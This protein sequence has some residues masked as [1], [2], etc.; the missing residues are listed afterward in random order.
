MDFKK[1]MRIKKTKMRKWMSR[2]SPE[3][4]NQ[5]NIILTIYNTPIVEQQQHPCLEGNASF[6]RDQGSQTDLAVVAGASTGNNRF[7]PKQPL[8]LYFSEDCVIM[9]WP[10]R[11]TLI[12]TSS[13]KAALQNQRFMQAT[14]TTVLK[15]PL[16]QWEKL[17]PGGWRLDS[18]HWRAGELVLVA[19]TALSRKL[20]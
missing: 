7:W 16:N 6:S 2:L 9:L 3:K 15:I 11:K 5:L 12:P 10:H 20:D 18:I 13:P 14:T 19:D 8:I 17:S 1:Q 4:E